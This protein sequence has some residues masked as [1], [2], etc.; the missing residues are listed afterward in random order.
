MGDPAIARMS[1]IR[2]GHAVVVDG[3]TT[4]NGKQVVAIRDPAGGLQY[5]T[6]VNEFL[7]SFSG[8]A[9]F[10]KVKR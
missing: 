9:A 5:F 1:L 3:I 4:K 8:E 2:G 7:N 10:T 6:P